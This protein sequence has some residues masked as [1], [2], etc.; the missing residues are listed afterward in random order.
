[1]TQNQLAEEFGISRGQVCHA[2]RRVRE[3]RKSSS[4]D[5]EDKRDY[6]DDD[7]KNCIK[8]MVEYQDQAAKLDRKQVKTNIRIKDEKPIGVAY[9]G[10]WHI[11]A[12]GVN[13]RAFEEDLR[14][15]RDTE[16][17]YFIGA[18]DY[19]DNYIDGAPPGGQYEQIIQPGMQD[20]AVQ[21]YL[22]QVGEKCL[23]LIRGCHDD[24]DKKSGDKDFLEYLSYITDS[25][26]LWHGGEVTIKLAEQEYFWRCRH[27][28]KYQSS[29]NL[30]NAMRRIMEIQGPCDVAA[31]AHLHN[32]YV[33]ARHLMGQYRFMLRSGTYKIW[34]EYGQKLA[35]YKGK[36]SVP[37]VLMRP[38]RHALLAVLF[39]DEAIDILSAIRKNF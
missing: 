33:M 12:G 26:N 24:W 4:I 20:K 1:M 31:E 11:G 14:K 2:L 5:Y 34:D 28:Y 29:L 7:V 19:K 6:T 25:V 15:I 30:E 37:V 16:G 39:I 38:D 23:A 9:W 35:G 21:Y 13:Y 8:A 10:D 27:R 17:L 32:G 22:E 3:E 36:P 18:G